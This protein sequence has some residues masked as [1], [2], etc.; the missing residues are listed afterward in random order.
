MCTLFSL[1]KIE[2]IEKET[3]HAFPFFL[4]NLCSGGSHF[5]LIYVSYFPGRLDTFCLPSS[6]TV[7]FLLAWNPSQNADLLEI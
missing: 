5:L 6:P 7:Y 4:G 2:E 1:G 3:S